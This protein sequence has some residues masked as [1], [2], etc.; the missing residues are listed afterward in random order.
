MEDFVRHRWYGMRQR[1]PVRS[2]RN[3]DYSTVPAG[4]LPAYM[5]ASCQRG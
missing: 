5:G 3:E 1:A 2:P 4:A